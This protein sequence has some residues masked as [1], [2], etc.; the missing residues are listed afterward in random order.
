MAALAPPA[1]LAPRRGRSV[2]AQPP[3]QSC[4]A[5]WG[6][7]DVLPYVPRNVRRVLEV[8]CGRGGFGRSLRKVLGPSAELVAMEAVPS[9]A[10]VARETGAFDR[11]HDGYF[12]SALPPDE[13]GFDLICFNDVLEHVVDPWSTVAACRDLLAPG[14]QVLAAIPNVQHGPTVVGL[15]RGHWDYQDTGVLDRTHLRFFTR[16]SAIGLFR[17]TGYSVHTCAPANDVFDE[18]H[19][20][21]WRWLAPLSRDFRWMHFILLAQPASADEDVYD[22]EPSEEPQPGERPFRPPRPPSPW[23]RLARRA[24]ALLR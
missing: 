2:S 12:P 22:V 16:E 23:R 17:G 5:E 19:L 1:T 3:Q 15:L 24:R 20:R 6:R 14:G 21:R 4:Y 8:G 11:V 18:P 9:Q 13:S 7:D 10:A